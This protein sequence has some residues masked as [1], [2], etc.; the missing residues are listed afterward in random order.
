[1]PAR[2]VLVSTYRSCT[3]HGISSQDLSAAE[4]GQ[5]GTMD[6]A[7]HEKMKPNAKLLLL[8]RDRSGYTSRLVQPSAFDRPADGTSTANCF[9]R[10]SVL[11]MATSMAKFCRGAV[12]RYA[13][14][15]TGVRWWICCVTP[16]AVAVQALG[17]WT[18]PPPRTTGTAASSTTR[19]C[20]VSKASC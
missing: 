9:V 14:V 17:T 5:S 7:I 6:R 18:R 1:M 10:S 4:F 2:S 13:A 8:H 12:R 19:R 11:A 15:E 3:T 16:G 20:R